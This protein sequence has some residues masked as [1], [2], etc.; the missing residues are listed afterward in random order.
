M[1]LARAI[2]EAGLVSA[3][4]V[5]SVTPV[6]L[7]AGGPGEAEERTRAAFRDSTDGTLIIDDAFTLSSADPS[8]RAVLKAVLEEV[9][10]SASQRRRGSRD[11]VPPHPPVAPFT[12]PASPRPG[13]G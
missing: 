8:P 7:T 1:L 3:G 5:V 6:D 2:K 4:R 9:S 13:T 11:H 12:P 10:R